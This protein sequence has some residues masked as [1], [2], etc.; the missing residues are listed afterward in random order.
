MAVIKYDCC[1]AVSRQHLIGLLRNACIH[2]NCLIFVCIFGRPS[3]E[4]DV[5]KKRLLRN[6]GHE[7]YIVLVVNLLITLQ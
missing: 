2:F 6:C 4:T 3:A 5:Q 7:M 1:L